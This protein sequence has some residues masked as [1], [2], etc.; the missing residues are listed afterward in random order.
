MLPRG[1]T[2]AGDVIMFQDD[3]DDDGDGHEEEEEDSAIMA[4]ADILL[5][6]MNEVIEGPGES[7][8]G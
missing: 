2:S 7:D 4:K 6:A 8:G 1:A 5:A 3:G